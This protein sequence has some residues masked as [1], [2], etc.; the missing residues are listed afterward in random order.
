MITIYFSIIGDFNDGNIVDVQITPFL[1]CQYV[2]YVFSLTLFLY[3]YRA[4]CVLQLKV[5]Q[6]VKGTHKEF[7]QIVKIYVVL[8]FT[9]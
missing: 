9:Y 2:R 1:Y 5:P 7:K 8:K 3:P 6:L 4:Q